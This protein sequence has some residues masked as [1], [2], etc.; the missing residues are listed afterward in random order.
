MRGAQNL[1]IFLSCRIEEGRGCRGGGRL[2][3]C[4]GQEWQGGQDEGR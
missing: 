2:P 1:L 4:G 3:V